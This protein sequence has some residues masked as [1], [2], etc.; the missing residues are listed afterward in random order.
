[1]ALMFGYYSNQTDRVGCALNA[2][3]ETLTLA[4]G[5]RSDGWGIG[6]YQGGEVLLRKRP[7][8][9]RGSIDFVEMARDL[10]ADVVIGHVR[11]ATVG[12]ARVENTH[13]FRYRHWLFAHNGTI[14]RFASVRSR[15]LD[16]I[17]DFLRRNIRGETDSEHLFHLFLAFLFDAGKLEDP[18]LD[19]AHAMETI[20]SSIALLDR[21]TSEVGHTQPAAFNVMATNGR[22]LLASRRG[23]PLSYVRREGMRDCPLCRTPADRSDRQPKRVDHESLR[24]V[25]CASEAART[26]PD[27]TEVP[28]NSVVGVRRDLNVRVAAL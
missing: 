22:I 15:L 2:E 17:P 1:M 8:E 23:L 18:E 20:R 28:E 16:S 27:W 7:Q 26:T 5:Q 11:S 21:L 6:F 19:T 24:Y 25:L 3:R 13:P 10:H 9:S 4:D 14:E 12:A